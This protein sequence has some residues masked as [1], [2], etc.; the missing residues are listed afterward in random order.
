M[1]DTAERANAARAKERSAREEEETKMETDLKTSVTQQE[2]ARVSEGEGESDA[3]GEARTVIVQKIEMEGEYD[4][5]VGR[6]GGDVIRK[7]HLLGK[8][9]YSE[10]SEKIKK[11]S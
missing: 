10:K 6:S 8:I 7:K 11:K 5:E 1:K 2:D 9:I 3:D 4:A